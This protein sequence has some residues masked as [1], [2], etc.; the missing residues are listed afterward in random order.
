MKNIKNIILPFCLGSLVLASC[1][2][3]EEVN[4]DPTK[5]S[6]DQMKVEYIINESLTKAQQDPDVAERAFVL[7]W[8][9]AARQQWSN[10]IANGSYNDGWISNYYDQS[11]NWQTSINL[12]IR[13]ADEKIENGLSGDD[14]E[15]VPNYKQ[16]ARIWRVYLMSEFVDNFGALPLNGF[17]GVNPT[18]SNTKDVY[19]FMLSELKDAAAQMNPSVTV[20]DDDKK[21]DRA[22]KF[23]FAKWIK[24]ANS[25]RLRLAMRL[26]EVDPQKAQ[27]EFEEAVKGSLIQSPD[28][29]FTCDERPG[30]DALTGVMTREWNAQLLSATLNNLMI[31]IGGVKST[32]QP[33]SE[34]A[35][36]HIKPA[37][38]MGLKYDKHFSAYTNDPSAGFWY[39]GLYEKMDPRAYALFFIP[40]D[41]D[42]ENYCYY[43]SWTQDA[44]TQ[45]KN[46]YQDDKETVLEKVDASYTWNAPAIGSYGDKG[47]KNE[48]YN[49][50]GTCPGLSLDYRDSQNSRIFFASWETDFLI[51]EAALRGWNVPMSAKQAYEAGV[52]ASFEYNGVSQFVDEYL[53]SKEYNRV[54]TSAAWD[55]TAEPPATVQMTMK[56]GY[57]KAEST[58]TFTY[59]VASNTLYGKALNDHLTKIITQKYLANMPWLPLE[60]WSDHRRLGLPFFETPCVEQP[61]IYIPSLTK[62]NYM[63]AKIEYY[64]QRLKFPSK[65]ETSNPAAYSEIESVLGGKDDVFTPMWWA[66]H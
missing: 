36:A 29:N 17:T 64:P 49:Y 35:K 46:L 56:D 22:Y 43:P 55:H 58:Y 8:K 65:L 31:N 24:Y 7:N 25:M 11:A 63:K 9:T 39:D 16:V 60:A 62:G 27:S 40:G 26:S 37:N 21:Y 33:I 52:R 4:V 48:L 51:A 19:Y 18:F 61:L 23:D 34:A 3:F 57:T 14:A 30:W 45:I 6:S 47:A 50:S 32:D 5:A 12:A 42:D 1:S 15:K 53:A 54:G 2:D 13:L 38:Y 59:P 66:K 20:T 28:D 41:F 44:K 10:G